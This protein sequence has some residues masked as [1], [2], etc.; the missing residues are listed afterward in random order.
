MYIKKFTGE[1]LDEL[2]DRIT[3]ELGP[4]AIVLATRTL[5]TGF[6]KQL[7]S[8]EEF[9]VTV[10]IETEDLEQHYSELENDSTRIDAREKLRS[11]AMQSMQRLDPVSFHSPE[12]KVMRIPVTGQLEFDAGAKNLLVLVGHP[13]VGKTT[14]LAKLA[15]YLQKN[16]PHKAG[17]VSMGDMKQENADE[18]H[19]FADMFNL[20]YFKPKNP[21]ELRTMMGE[22]TNHDIF[23]LDTP[24]DYDVVD[25]A[26]YLQAA[27]V[28][29]TLLVLSA[30]DSMNAQVQAVNKYQPLNP[31][32]LIITKL[33]ENPDIMMLS[34]LAM[35]QNIPFSFLCE[36]SDLTLADA[37]ELEVRIINERLR[38][39]HI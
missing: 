12:P 27:S 7:L 14:T 33:T 2:Q 3:E 32:G 37:D 38:I 4:N 1:N 19:G 35:H 21:Q 36:G 15:L 28:S 25:I 29:Q 20:N 26:A 8:L 9:E 22:Q 31:R 23:L 11:M 6:F 24:G 16:T 5:D 39:N 18:L 30:A 10:G 17:L 13:N 34:Q